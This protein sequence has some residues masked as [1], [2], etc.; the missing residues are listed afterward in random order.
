[1]IRKIETVIRFAQT[2]SQVAAEWQG[3]QKMVKPVFGKR[4]V[5]K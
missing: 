5:T 4:N 2:E 3:A 1:M